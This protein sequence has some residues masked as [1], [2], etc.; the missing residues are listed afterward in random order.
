MWYPTFESEFNFIKQKF[1][2]TSG[3]EH[4]HLGILYYKLDKSMYM[5]DNSF[6]PGIAQF[7]GL[8]YYLQKIITSIDLG[9]KKCAFVGI[10]KA[11]FYLSKILGLNSYHA[12]ALVLI[13]VTICGQ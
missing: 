8:F 7:T 12:K 2:T 6:H 4:Y 5:V 10:Q 1:P 13:K 11:K 9:N 3:Q